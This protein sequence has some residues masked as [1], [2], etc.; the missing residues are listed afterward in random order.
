M[1][2][3][4]GLSIISSSAKSLIIKKMWSL[5]RTHGVLC[6]NVS[7]PNWDHDRSS[8]VA[9]R[10]QN[11][12][13]KHQLTPMVLPQTDNVAG[14][15]QKPPALSIGPEYNSGSPDCSQPLPSKCSN[16]IRSNCRGSNSQSGCCILQ[17]AAARA[18][19]VLGYPPEDITRA[20]LQ[21]QYR[22]E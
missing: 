12:N 4:C 11:A 10:L 5:Y 20:G 15:Q 13:I 3:H 22:G 9:S 17:G 19:L 6:T 1:Y 2:T 18:L 14:R 16:N 7:K 8:S 21:I